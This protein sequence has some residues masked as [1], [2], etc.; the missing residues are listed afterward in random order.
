M[1]EPHAVGALK[2]R[3]KTKSATGWFVTDVCIAIQVT[4]DRWEYRGD[5]EE[6]KAR[7]IQKPVENKTDSKTR[8]VVARKTHKAGGGNVGTQLKVGKSCGV[9]VW[10][11]STFGWRGMRKAGE[12]QKGRATMEKQNHNKAIS[13]HRPPHLTAKT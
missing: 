10:R 6:S 8:K 3:S 12:G 5:R 7:E 9:V 4:V 11:L 1:E 13:R 2:E